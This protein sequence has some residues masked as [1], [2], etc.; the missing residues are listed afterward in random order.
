MICSSS[1][2]RI[3]TIYHLRFGKIHLLLTHDW[4]SHTENIIRCFLDEN[5]CTDMAVPDNWT[6]LE[7]CK[8]HPPYEFPLWKLLADNHFTVPGHMQLFNIEFGVPSLA[9]TNSN[10]TLISEVLRVKKNVMFCK[11]R[12]LL[13]SQLQRG[14]ETGRQRS[15]SF[16]RW[17]Y[18]PQ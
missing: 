5:I 16:L 1:G 4:T 18:Q 14:V 9:E 13:S 6:L 12:P 10:I 11:W 17:K 8:H 3:F 2:L 15:A 7:H